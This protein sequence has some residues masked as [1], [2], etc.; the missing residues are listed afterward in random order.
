MATDIN[1]ENDKIIR[2]ELL[3]IFRMQEKFY[4]VPSLKQQIPSMSSFHY[5]VQVPQ[6]KDSNNAQG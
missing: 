4:E 6:N 5:Q 2:G 3:C 1:G